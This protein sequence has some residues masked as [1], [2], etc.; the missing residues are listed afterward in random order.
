MDSSGR[1]VIMRDFLEVR[2]FSEGLA[3]VRKSDKWGYIDKTGKTIIDFKYT[4]VGNF[5]NGLAWAFYGD[6]NKSKS[7]IGFYIDKEGNEYYQA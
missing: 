5:E 2:D 3:A 1:E 6:M 7:I 4:R